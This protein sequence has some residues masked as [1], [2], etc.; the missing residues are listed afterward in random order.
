M[1]ALHCINIKASNGKFRVKSTGCNAADFPQMQNKSDFTEE[2]QTRVS[3][4]PLSRIFFPF[5]SFEGAVKVGYV[6]SSA[7]AEGEREGGG[8]GG[9][10][11][12]HLPPA[13]MQLQ[14]ATAS[15]ELNR[16]F[17]MSSEESEKG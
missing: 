5:S 7:A 10:P 15:S 2:G 8:G 17:N 9:P 4:P 14:A 1:S 13:K 3:E 16:S 12:V 6:R 11:S